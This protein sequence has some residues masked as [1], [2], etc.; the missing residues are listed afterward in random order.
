MNANV[1]NILSIKGKSINIVLVGLKRLFIKTDPLYPIQLTILKYVYIIAK[2]NNVKTYLMQKIYIAK[3]HLSYIIYEC[4]ATHQFYKAIL[5]KKK[6]IINVCLWSPN[7]NVTKFYKQFDRTNS[8]RYMSTTITS[9]S[10]MK[11]IYI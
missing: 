6:L 7:C 1:S 9:G 11:L 8:T 2:L 4:K 3:T 10:K 5:C